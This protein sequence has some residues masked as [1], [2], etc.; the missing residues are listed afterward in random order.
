MGDERVVLG[1]ITTGLP[2]I[3]SVSSGQVIWL[4]TLLL[5]C[6]V[7]ATQRRDGPDDGGPE[8]GGGGG[9][10]CPTKATPDDASWYQALSPDLEPA[11]GRPG[12]RGSA[13]GH[14]RACPRWVNAAVS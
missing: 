2:A 3:A 8:N 7:L 12:R 1:V 10:G 9:F 11:A 14:C 13:P 4:V 5:G 6:V